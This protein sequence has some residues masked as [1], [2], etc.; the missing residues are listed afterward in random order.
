MRRRRSLNLL[1]ARGGAE[2]REALLARVRSEMPGSPAF[3]P[4]LPRKSEEP[5]M[6]QLVIVP[7]ADESGV[8]GAADVLKLKPS[9]LQFWI[10]K[11]GLRAELQRARGMASGRE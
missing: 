8:G 4:A 7:F 11:L 10:D 2:W 6:G 5:S 3:G 1:S 9:T